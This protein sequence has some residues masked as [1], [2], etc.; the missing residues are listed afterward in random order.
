MNIGV[1]NAAGTLNEMLESHIDL[2]VPSIISFKLSEYKEAL[3]DWGD[4]TLA[5]VQLD[6]HGPFTGT[7]MLVFPSDSAVKLVAAL[8]NEEPGSAGLDAVM[9]GTLNEVGNI[10]INA[11][12][13]SIGN[14]LE[15]N[16]DFSLPNYLE[17]K[18]E[19]LLNAKDL[20][21]DVTVLLVQTNFIVKNLEINGK[22]FMIFKL[23]TFGK[24]LT[25][26]DEIY[27]N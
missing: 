27:C 2:D 14:L 20:S 6:F 9:A 4:D 15:N 22:V 21:E 12:M 16:I 11:V 7:S 10:V 19:D 8:T 3:A 25:T 5:S 13:G 24:L 18:F 23:G 17:G 26:I 1:G